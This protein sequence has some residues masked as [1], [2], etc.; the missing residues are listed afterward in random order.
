MTRL[1]DSLAELSGAYD[2][3]FCDLWGCVHNGIRPFPE[4]V[5]ALQSFR[6]EGGAVVLMTNAPRPERTVR[7]M[8]E[9]MALA[10][11][12]FDLI[13]S[14]GDAA[15]RSM[16]AG[17]AGRRVW[18]IGT[19]KDLPFFEDIPEHL[20]DHPPVERVGFSEAEGIVCTGLFDE[21][22]ESPEDY[23]GRF[24][25]ARD[26]GL[27]MLCANPDIVV[28]WGDR[29]L[30]CA[31]ALAAL[32]TEIGGEAL[33]FGKPYPPIYDMA[34]DRLAR[35][36]RSTPD[37]RILALGDGIE[38]D[39]RGGMGEG[40]DT[41]FITGGLAAGEFGGTPDRPDPDKLTAWLDERQATPTFAMGRLR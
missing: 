3:L 6:A 35:I 38:T 13:V 23:R 25:V 1:I 21:M 26:R 39:I 29:R 9:A 12:S 16:F 31:G 14:S 8:L 28:D 2:T 18:H 36:G 41:L 34:R 24:L 7:A 33:Y 5:R 30:W 11:D 32:Y 22:A 10:Q 15:Q 40:I 27:R 19:E 37:E 20:G 17:D 4:A